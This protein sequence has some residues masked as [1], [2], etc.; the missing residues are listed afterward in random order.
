VD[1]LRTNGYWRGLCGKIL[2]A[3]VVAERSGGNGF[4]LPLVCAGVFFGAFSWVCG[5]TW[6]VGRLKTFGGQ[7]WLRWIDFGGGVLLLA[8]ALGA[9]WRLAA[10][11]L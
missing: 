4:G 2:G 7:K 11:T 10:S 3:G 1:E 8:F 6:V 9:I 5:F